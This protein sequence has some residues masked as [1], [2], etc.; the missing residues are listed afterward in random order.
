VWRPDYSVI[1]LDTPPGVGPLSTG[2]E[3]THKVSEGAVMH[4]AH[5]VSFRVCRASVRLAHT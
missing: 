3:H 1:L 5:R 4:I 2:L